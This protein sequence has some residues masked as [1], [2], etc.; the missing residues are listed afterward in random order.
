MEDSLLGITHIF[1]YPSDIPFISWVIKI[2][3]D[4]MYKT[5]IFEWNDTM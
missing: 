1:F 4:N 3:Y 5:P 2:G